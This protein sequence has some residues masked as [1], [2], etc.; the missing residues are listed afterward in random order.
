MYSFHELSRRGDR[1]ERMGQV[2]ETDRSDVVQRS[3]NRLAAAVRLLV[4]EQ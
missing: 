1:S 3:V 2:P 4:R